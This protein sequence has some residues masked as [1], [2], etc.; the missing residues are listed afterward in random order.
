MAERDG[1]DLLLEEHPFFKGMNPAIRQAISGC[2]VNERFKVGEYIFQEGS[3][4]NRFY[5]IRTGSVNLEVDDAGHEPVVVDILGEGD[6]LGWSWMVPPYKY[7]LDAR[8]TKLVRTFSV[9]GRCLREKS[10]NDPLLANELFKRFVPVMAAR[11]KA[12]RLKMIDLSARTR[13]K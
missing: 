1:L 9:D 4:A 6:I 5:L 3:A 7:L 8:V 2:I 13:G 11:L 12:G 10:E